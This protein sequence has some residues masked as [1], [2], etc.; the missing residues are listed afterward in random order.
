[1]AG[2]LCLDGGCVERRNKSWR[3]RG[4]YWNSGNEGQQKHNKFREQTETPLSL[5]K[6]KQQQQSQEGEG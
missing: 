2:S 4:E 5:I 6:P 3:Y 1:M